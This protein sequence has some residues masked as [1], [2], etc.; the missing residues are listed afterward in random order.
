M[1]EKID[2]AFLQKVRELRDRY[3]EHVNSNDAALPAIGK[4]DAQ[5]ALPQRGV[6]LAALPAPIAA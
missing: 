5:R 3:L 1:N 4:Y 2:L 6:V